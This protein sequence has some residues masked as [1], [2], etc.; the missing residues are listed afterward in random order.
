MNFSK[1]I[2]AVAV[3]FSIAAVPGWAQVANSRPAPSAAANSAKPK[4]MSNADVIAL[5]A[6]GLPDDIVI[7][8]IQAASL[9]NFDTSLDGLKSLKAANVSDAV[10]RVMID[11]HAAAATLTPVPSGLPTEDGVYYKKQGVYTEIE[12]EVAKFRMGML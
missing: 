5:A 12:P 11:P 1:H 4:E 2:L 6:A 7:A 9:T 10:I 3:A 8:K